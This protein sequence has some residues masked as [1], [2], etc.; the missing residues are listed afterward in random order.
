GNDGTGSHRAPAPQVRAAEPAEPRDAQDDAE[1][2]GVGPRSQLGGPRARHLWRT[3]LSMGGA[4]HPGVRETPVPGRDE[5][6]SAG[7]PGGHRRDG[8]L[9]VSALMTS[10][11]HFLVGALGASLALATKGASATPWNRAAYHKEPQSRVLVVKASHYALDLADV[12]AHALR[13]YGLSVAGKKVVLKPNLVEFD[14]AG[15]IN[16]HPALIGATIDAF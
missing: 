2:C 11:R 14:P 15:V 4:P 13:D 5:D 1:L 9:P 7:P 8:G 10:R 12:V 3:R 6:S 16:T